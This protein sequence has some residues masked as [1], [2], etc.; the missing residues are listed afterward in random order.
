LSLY[1]DR[2]H[3]SSLE[4]SHRDDFMIT[5]DK[6]YFQ[7][8]SSFNIKNIKK[9]IQILPQTCL[10]KYP[11]HFRTHGVHIDIVWITGRDLKKDLA[12]TTELGFFKALKKEGHEINVFSPTE[13]NNNNDTYE[14]FDFK[15]IRIK[16]LETLSGGYFLNRKLKKSEIVK[17]C[18]VILIDWRFVANVNKIVNKLK[19]PWYIIDRGPPVYDTLLTKIHKKIW[20]RAWKIADKNANGGFVVSKRHEYLI[21]KIKVNLPI[22]D[23]SAGI[24]SND[25]H[26]NEHKDIS[27]HINFVY[28]GRLDKNRGMEKLIQFSKIMSNLSLPSKLHIMGEGDYEEKIK[29]EAKKNK[30][31]LFHGRLDKEKVYDIMKISHFGIMPMPNSEIWPT[32]SPIKLIEYIASGMLVIGEMHAG[33]MVDEK[34]GGWSLL[35][36]GNEWPDKSIDKIEE[37][38]EH[39]I[40]MKLSKEAKSKSKE[41]DW[42]NITKEMLK[43]IKIN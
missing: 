16:G 12:S 29:K 17:D 23:L 2:H 15:K 36:H 31:L 13:N 39:N 26:N 24:D 28:S 38:M 19:I 5:R 30:S 14:H 10:I 22:K 40:F 18:D 34:D 43:F 4:R 6:F 9:C 1:A 25:F 33:N 41:L 27:K 11:H 37:I 7:Y 20:K 35:I 32:S 42:D 3:L 8:F 21:R